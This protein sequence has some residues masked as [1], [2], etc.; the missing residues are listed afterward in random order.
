MDSASGL[1]A[2]IAVLGVCLAGTLVLIIFLLL[3]FCVQRKKGSTKSSVAV[4]N[5]IMHG[6]GECGVNTSC[7]INCDKKEMTYIINISGLYTR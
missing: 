3:M 7:L 5:M 2:G 1:V 6:E 4:V